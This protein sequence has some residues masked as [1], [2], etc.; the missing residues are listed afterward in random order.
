MLSSLFSSL[1]F[2]IVV[3]IVCLCVYIFSI[4]LLSFIFHFII[5]FYFFFFFFSSRRR[6]TRCALVTGVQTCALPIFVA[7]TQRV[8]QAVD[9][10]RHD[11]DVEKAGRGDKCE[12]GIQP[13]PVGS[14]RHRGDGGGGVRGRAHAAA[15]VSS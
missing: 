5:C 14:L 9:D 11:V 8:D 6:H 2:V 3:F 4:S 10:R 13:Q 12:Q 7:E 1:M 15:P